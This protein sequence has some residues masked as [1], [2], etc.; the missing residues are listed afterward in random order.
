[1]Q[2]LQRPENRTKRIVKSKID[3]SRLLQKIM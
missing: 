2:A 3:F 1:L